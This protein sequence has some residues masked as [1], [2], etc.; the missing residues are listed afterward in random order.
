[1]SKPFNPEE[2]V[3]WDGNE[4]VVIKEVFKSEQGNYVYS[5]WPVSAEPWVRFLVFHDE[6]KPL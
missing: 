4:E 6:L 3:D 2:H 5:I 1:M